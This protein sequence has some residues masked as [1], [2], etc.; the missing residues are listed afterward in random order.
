M[1]II[2]FFISNLLFIIIFIGLGYL[3]DENK[4]NFI[5]HL[6]QNW[7]RYLLTFIIVSLINYWLDRRNKNK[8]NQ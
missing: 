8:K 4:T 6:S 2:K 5:N 7:V 3:M 1:N